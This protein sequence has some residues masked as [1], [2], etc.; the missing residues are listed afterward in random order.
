[1]AI[2]AAA[3]CVACIITRRIIR[4]EEKR[5][6]MKIARWC[7]GGMTAPIWVA[8]KMHDRLA[9]I[10]LGTEVVSIAEDMPR[11]LGRKLRWRV[12]KTA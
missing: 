10:A 3:L 11:L 5:Y 6:W 4:P 1:M 7:E 9:A 12:I 2:S 8:R